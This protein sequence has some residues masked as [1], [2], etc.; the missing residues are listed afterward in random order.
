MTHASVRA[1]AEHI[2]RAGFIT[3]HQLAALTAHDESLT[4]DQ[5]QSF[6]DAWRA[7]GSPATAPQDPGIRNLQSWL[8]YLTSTQVQQESRGKIQPLTPSEACGFI[9]C[10][11][12]ETGRPSLDRLD[13]IESGSG[14]GR[15]AMQYTGVRRTAYDKARSLALAKGADTNGNRWQQQYFAE[16]YA[17][18]HD[19]PEGSLIG[20]TRVF[21]NRPA[22]MTPEQAA[23]YWTGSAATRTGYFRPGVPHLD[24]RQR[25]AQRAWALVRSGALQPVG[26]AKPNT[27]RG[28]GI[29]V[30]AGM[31]GPR[32]APTLKA[33][34][35]HL[36]ADDRRQIMTAYTHDGARLWSIPCLCRGQAGET[37]WKATGSDT[38]PGLYK[39]G[40]IYRDYEQDPSPRF[41]ED[42][43]S[44]G[45]YSVDLEGQ[46]GQEGPDS[47]PHRDGIMIHGGGTACG[48]PGAWAPRQTLHPTL[49]C[50]RCHNT[51]LRD[52]ILPLLG[53]GT[54]WVSVLQE[55]P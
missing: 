50:I 46:E 20:W 23:E 15:G 22:G 26:T 24:R 37:E 9:G 51:D 6:T 49:G 33:G 47:K 21:E 39:V 30:P 42:R 10:I 2:A 11:I 14:A 34:D 53:M 43:R 44:Y 54:V 3:P 36:V 48:W 17:G 55:A 40:K 7:Q 19:P 25:E 41:T 35:H 8:S 28:S 27:T 5:R 29:E 16:E 38:P 18:L 4:P 31:A 52:R 13:V 1:A 45:W 32:K 12:V